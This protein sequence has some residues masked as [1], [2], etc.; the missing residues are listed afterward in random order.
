MIRQCVHHVLVH[1]FTMSPVYTEDRGIQK[2]SLDP[3][4]KPRDASFF[5][6]C[7][8][9]L[10]SRGLTAGSRFYCNKIKF[11]LSKIKKLF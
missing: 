1:V 11:V 5:Y 2:V 3:A 8:F 4:V 7:N 6:C 9:A 10:T